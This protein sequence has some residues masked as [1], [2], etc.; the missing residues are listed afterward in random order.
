MTL[1]IPINA[2]LALLVAVLL[3][4][5]A[6]AIS[7]GV[8]EW[9]EADTSDLEA[10]LES[11]AARIERIERQVSGRGEEDVTADQLYDCLGRIIE[12]VGIREDI[13][14]GM[15]GLEAL[16]DWASHWNANCVR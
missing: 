6:F 11:L 10:D 3:L 13:S 15:D 8:V 1:H 16:A 7:F 9:R 12:Y 4:G 14:A 5:G 2:V